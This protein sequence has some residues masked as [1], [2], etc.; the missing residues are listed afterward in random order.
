MN[1]GVAEW[2]AVGPFERIASSVAGRVHFRGA[3]TDVYLEGVRP[4]ACVAL[5]TAIARLRIE[6]DAAS[7]ATTAVLGEGGEWRLPARAARVHEAHP[8]LFVAP[9]ARFAPTAAE[10]RTIRWL[11]RLLRIPGI[12]RLIR[13]WQ[14]WRTR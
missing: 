10:E 4:E 6:R 14:A 8:E 1:A 11:L 7:G 12:T 5:P 13:V 3:R 2:S 9:L